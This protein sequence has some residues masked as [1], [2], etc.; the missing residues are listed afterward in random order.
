MKYVPT[1]TIGPIVGS[2]VGE[3]MATAGSIVA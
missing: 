1:G 3:A 2:A